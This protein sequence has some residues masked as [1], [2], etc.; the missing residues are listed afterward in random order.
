MILLL[1]RFGAVS[2]VKKDL[3]SVVAELFSVPK[4]KITARQINEIWDSGDGLEDLIL[5]NREDAEYTLRLA[6]E[7]FRAFKIRNSI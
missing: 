5:Y 3:E 6:T 7:Y 2:L 4:K 1:S